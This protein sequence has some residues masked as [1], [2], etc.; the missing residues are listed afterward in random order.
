M[1][2]LQLCKYMNVDLIVWRFHKYLNRFA[3]TSSNN[4]W[5]LFTMITFIIK[6]VHHT[7]LGKDDSIRHYLLHGNYNV[8]SLFPRKYVR[9]FSKIHSSCLILSYL[10]LRNVNWL[11]I[12]IDDAN[13]RATAYPVN[14]TSLTRFG[15]HAIFSRF[16]YIFCVFC[17]RYLFN[18]L[19]QFFT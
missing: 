10:R 8:S 2:M 17:Y 9:D 15:V 12:C 18:F 1:Q 5:T 3:R 7:V 11:S 16:L 14:L 19:D 4:I 6:T 13:I